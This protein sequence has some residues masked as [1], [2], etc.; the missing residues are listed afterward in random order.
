MINRI[1]KEQLQARKSKN[2]LKGGILTALLS[3]IIAI[4]KNAGNRETSEQEAVKVIKKFND[5]AKETLKLVKDQDKINI[6]NQEVKIYESF[7]PKALSEDETS[8]IIDDIFS[9]IEKPNIGL[10][11]K[12]LKVNHVEG[13][14]MG[15]A[16]KII[17]QKLG[18]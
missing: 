18:M 11:M 13:L 16:N 4:G 8:K 12:E 15:L 7:L 5:N 6:L 10:M 1:K 14:D 3:E 2:K 9:K 17:K